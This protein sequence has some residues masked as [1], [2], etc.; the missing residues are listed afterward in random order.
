MHRFCG[1]PLSY[2]LSIKRGT[3]STRHLS[4]SVE[5][6]LDR[7]GAALRSDA[8]DDLLGDLACPP[9]LP[10]QHP[11]VDALIQEHAAV[12]ENGCLGLSKADSH[13]DWYF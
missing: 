4:G 12:E 11:V 9:P 7:A 1:S 10:I 13:F 6:A 3:L 8:G 5:G 2:V